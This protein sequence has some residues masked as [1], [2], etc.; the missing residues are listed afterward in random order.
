MRTGNT[1]FFVLGVCVL[2]LVIAW[3]EHLRAMMAPPPPIVRG[4]WEPDF[5]KGKP[6]PDF[7]LPDAKG[8]Q[9]AL[10]SFTGKTTTLLVFTEFTDQSVKLFDYVKALRNRMGKH[11]PGVLVVAAFKRERE[12]EFRRK[13]GIGAPI[14]YEVKGGP[15]AELYKADPYPRAFVIDER[16]ILTSTGLSRSEASMFI[17]GTTIADALHF[18]SPGSDYL[19][20]RA[21]VPVGLDDTDPLNPRRDQKA[22]KRMMAPVN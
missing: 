15:I 4:K 17:I 13:T 14:L 6:P 12:S 20:M 11:A 21:P 10:S 2:V 1:T 3:A 22:R 8:R 18:K 16:G 7:T 9:H 5:D 19:R